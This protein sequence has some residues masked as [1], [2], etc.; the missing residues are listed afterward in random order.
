MQNHRHNLFFFWG[1]WGNIC[2][3][4]Q[5]FFLHR[6]VFWLL[7]WR[8]ANKNNGGECG[9]KGCM[10][11]KDWFKPF[12]ALFLPWL[13]I[14]MVD[15]PQQCYWPS[16][17]Y[18]QRHTHLTQSVAVGWSPVH[19]QC[20][21][22]VKNVS[23]HVVKIFPL[24]VFRKNSFPTVTMYESTLCSLISVSHTQFMWLFCSPGLTL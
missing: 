8:G 13:L 16:Y 6:I 12:F 3:S 17:A 4:L 2:P 1:G 21:H 7:T 19:F 20:L 22:S 5:Y 18:G 23:S 10:Y 24:M 15:L 14:P 9:G 11:I